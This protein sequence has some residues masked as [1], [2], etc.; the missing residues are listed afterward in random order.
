MTDRPPVRALVIDDDPV[1]LLVTRRVLEHRGSMTVTTATGPHAALDLLGT[2][3]F[4]VVVTDVQMPE[5]SGLELLDQLRLLRPGLPVV[6]VTADMRVDNAL[7]VIRSRA[8]AF[9]FKPLD[10]DKLVRTVND[11]VCAA[12]VPAP[13]RRLRR[14]NR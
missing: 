14:A 6:I 12:Q 3:A 13:H 10:P 5:M 11:L 8:A 9:L 7:E 1:A 4:D 2:A